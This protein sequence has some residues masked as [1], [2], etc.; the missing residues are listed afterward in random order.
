MK[1]WNALLLLTSILVSCENEEYSCIDISKVAT[2]QDSSY[3][4]D[5]IKEK[6]KIKLSIAKNAPIVDSAVAHCRNGYFEMQPPE[7]LKNLV[8][9]S[10]PQFESWAKCKS[11]YFHESDYLSPDGLYFEYI[12]WG[13]NK[14][15][16]SILNLSGSG[17]VDTTRLHMNCK[18]KE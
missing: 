2:V 15:N 14:S 18:R 10:L 12:L 17:E 9:S 16:G 5:L 4:F 11:C 1:Y 6:W 3:V 13:F 8:K 7:G